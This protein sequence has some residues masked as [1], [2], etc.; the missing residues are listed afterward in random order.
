MGV[1]ESGRG[2]VELCCAFALEYLRRLVNFRGCCLVKYFLV[3]LYRGEECWH[4]F[5]ES[6]PP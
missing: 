5:M 6:W 4:R 3:I 1:F 2:L